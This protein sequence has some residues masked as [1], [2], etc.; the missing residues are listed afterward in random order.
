MNQEAVILALT[1]ANIVLA[2]ASLHSSH[3]LQRADKAAK[4]LAHDKDWLK[5]ENRSLRYKLNSLQDEV[6]GLRVVAMADKPA[7]TKPATNTR[8]IRVTD[9]GNNDVS[10]SRFSDGGLA[11]SSVSGSSSHSSSSCDS[12]SSSSSSSCDSSF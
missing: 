8:K 10:A 7:S 11:I 9:G 5:D 3:K 12:S 2:L 4:Q 1:V 6:R